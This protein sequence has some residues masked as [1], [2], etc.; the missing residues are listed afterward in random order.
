MPFTPFHLGFGIL[1]SA[2]LFPYIDPIA[3]L[4]GTILI[5]LEPLFHLIFSIGQ[6]HGVIHSFLGVI[7]FFIPI[8][9]ISWVSFK[10]ISK[11]FDYQYKF[12]WYLSLLSSILGLYSHIIFDAGLYS[13]MRLLYPFTN[14]TGY[15][16]GFWTSNIAMI[17]LSAM[18]ALGI[19]III[20]RLV[21]YQY[22]KKKRIKASKV[23]EINSPDTS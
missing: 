10:L 17:A 23:N 7:V 8:S 6:L 11:W 5:D 22:F 18:F 12:R 19:I 4:L 13:E 1:L 2:I 3:L 14:Q 16:F 9:V 21:V 15:L 20:I